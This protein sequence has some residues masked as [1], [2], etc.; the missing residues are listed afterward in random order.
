MRELSTVCLSVAVIPVDGFKMVSTS[1]I[2]FAAS[3][4]IFLA[5]KMLWVSRESAPVG[6]HYQI[7]HR[8]IRF[9]AVSAVFVCVST[10]IPTTLSGLYPRS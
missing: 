10:S 9:Y 5:S 1:F 7:W 8:S 6:V 2:S 4:S 3:A